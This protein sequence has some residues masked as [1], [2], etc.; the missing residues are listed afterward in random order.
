MIF[1][2]CVQLFSK[3]LEY[4]SDYC[5]DRLKLN[6]QKE[7]IALTRGMTPVLCFIVLFVTFNYG[8]FGQVWYLILAIPDLCLLYFWTKLI[9]YEL[10]LALLL[11]KFYQ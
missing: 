6:T 2:V 3:R 10:S 5:K 4:I 1:F 9:G 7:N 8:V 11:I